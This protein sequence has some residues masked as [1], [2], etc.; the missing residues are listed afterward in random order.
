MPEF[1]TVKAKVCQVFISH[2]LLAEVLEHLGIQRTTKKTANH[3]TTY[4]DFKDLYNKPI[5]Y[6]WVHH[7]N[8]PLSMPGEMLQAIEATS[9]GNH[10][11]R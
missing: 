9:I 8:F 11:D 10:G 5:I 6:P 1:G 7:G 3:G 2:Q 4:Q